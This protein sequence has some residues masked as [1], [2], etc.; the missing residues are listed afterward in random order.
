MSFSAVSLRQSVSQSVRASRSKDKVVPDRVARGQVGLGQVVLGDLASFNMAG[1]K[2]A[3][4][5]LGLPKL[6]NFISDDDDDDIDDPA[7]QGPGDL[8]QEDAE[9]PGPQPSTSQGPQQ[10]PQPS[11]SQEPQPSTSQ[12]PQPSSSQAP[13]RGDRPPPEGANYTS[14]KGK[15]PS[16]LKYKPVGGPHSLGA[17]YCYERQKPFAPGERPFFYMRCSDQGNKAKGDKRRAACKARCA[18]IM[19]AEGTFRMIWKDDCPAHSC[20]PMGARAKEIEVEVTDRRAKIYERAVLTHEMP[21]V[22]LN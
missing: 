12:G 10:E 13:Q 6:F 9:R 2:P 20:M 7:P 15:G 17:T 18:I 1:K 22:R 16:S 3:R 11:T 8:N 4:A 14:V 19:D 21:W 5:A